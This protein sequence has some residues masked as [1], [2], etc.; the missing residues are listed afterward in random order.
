M[1]AK[2]II[3]TLLSCTSVTATV[4][5]NELNTPDASFV[6]NT[7]PQLVKKLRADTSRLPVEQLLKHNKQSTK[8][9]G[10]QAPAAALS[11]N[12]APQMPGQQAGR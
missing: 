11:L 8:L 5:A 7:T 10:T 12:G 3:L 9:N 6:S 2:M 1:K 4:M